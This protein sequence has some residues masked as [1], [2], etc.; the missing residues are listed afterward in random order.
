MATGLHDREDLGDDALGADLHV[1]DINLKCGNCNFKLI[2]GL[3]PTKTRPC[4]LASSASNTIRELEELEEAHTSEQATTM[5]V[6]FAPGMTPVP[7]PLSPDTVHDIA[8]L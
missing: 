1:R 6:T 3:N 5:F 7:S 8:W 2:N 4:L